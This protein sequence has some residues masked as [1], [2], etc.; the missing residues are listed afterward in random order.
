MG[1]DAASAS[2]PLRQVLESLVERPVELLPVLLGIARREHFRDARAPDELVVA[3]IHD[4][5]EQR[6][7]AIIHRAL[8]AELGPS[9][10]IVVR[11]RASDNE[12]ALLGLDLAGVV[13]PEVRAALRRRH[14]VAASR[15][16]L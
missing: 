10:R 13:H 4:V 8:A 3:E 5:H 12:G 16:L 11:P 1:C 14:L 6:A 9:P 2:A 7:L 15:E